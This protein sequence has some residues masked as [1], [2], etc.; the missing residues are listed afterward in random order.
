MVEMLGTLKLLVTEPSEEASDPS[1]E[2]SDPSEEAS[3]P[4][5]AALDP[6]GNISSYIDK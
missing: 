1:E 3:E 2:A 4:S 5:E 6:R